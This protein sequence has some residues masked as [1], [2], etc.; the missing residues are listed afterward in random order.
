MKNEEINIEKFKEE[1]GGMYLLVEIIWTQVCKDGFYITPIDQLKP[2]EIPI[3]ECT[4]LEKIFLTCIAYI[5]DGEEKVMLLQYLLLLIY[6]NHQITQ[7][8][9]VEVRKSFLIVVVEY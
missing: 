3:G 9:K 6:G 8:V 4:E 2:K 7:G 5:Q 1:L